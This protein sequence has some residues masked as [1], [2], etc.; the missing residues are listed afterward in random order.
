KH[1]V[2]QI[3]SAKL[4]DTQQGRDLLENVDLHANSESTFLIT[5]DHARTRTTGYWF[6]NCYIQGFGN[7]VVRLN[8]A[9]NVGQIRFDNCRIHKN[10]GWGVVNVGGSEAVVDSIKFT[11]STLTDLATQLMDVWVAVKKIAV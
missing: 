1:A 6:T 8:N 10:G 5:S 11:N 4:A 2:L 3:S 7:G 9:V